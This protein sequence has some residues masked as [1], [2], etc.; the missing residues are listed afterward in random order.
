MKLHQLFFIF[1]IIISSAANAQ[2]KYEWKQ[3][4]SGGYTY[5][6]V[7]NDPM[8]ARFYTLKNGLLVILSPN[9]KEPR[10]SFRIPVRTGSNNDPKDHTGLAHYL[11]HLL[12]KGTD[13]FGSLD[14]ASEKNYLDQI[15]ELYEQ[16]NSTSDV[17]NRKT[18]YHKIDSVS[19]L[20]SRYSIAN[21]YMR[22]MSSI[23]SQA[24]NAHT[25]LEETVY[26]E[27]IPSN[28]VDKLLAVQAERF[29][30]PVFRIFHT[31]LEAVYEEKNRA[32]DNDAWKIQDAMHDLLFPTHNYGRQTTI[33]TIEHLK[34]PSLKAIRE[35]YNKYYVPN[36]MAIVMAGDFEP[37]Q[38]IRKIDSTFSYM[39]PGTLQEYQGPKEEPV[40]G[41]IV[42]NIYGPSAETM[43]LVYRLNG[44]GSR[45]AML[46]N[47]ASSILSNG[48]AGL[49]DLNINKQQKALGAGAG[50]YQYKDYGLFILL[51]SPR[52]DQTLEQV[53]DLLLEQIEMLKKGSF[54]ES[55]IKAIVSNYNLSELQAIE[56]NTYRTQDLVEEFIHNRAQDW[57]REV[58]LLDEMG[59]VSKKEIVEFANGFFGKDNYVVI[60]KRKGTDTTIVK[61]EKPPITPVQTN[62]GKTSPF[63]EAFVKQPLPPIKPVWLDFNKD[64]QKG[65]AGNADILYIPNKENSLYS[66]YYYFNMGSFNNKLL[67]LAMQY[68]QYLGTDKYTAEEITKQFYNLATSFNVSSTNEETYVSINGLQENFE[69]GTNLFEHL[70]QNCKPDVA[71]LEALKDRL[72]KSRANNKLNKQIIS[73]AM[74]NYALYGSQN[75]FNYTLSDEEI[76]KLNA[77]EL[78]NI[79]HTLMNYGHD[80]LYYGPQSLPALKTGIQK[81]HKMPAAWTSTPAAKKFERIKQTVNQVMF[82]DYDAVQAEVFWAKTLQP[83][84][85]GQE[86]L[87]DLYSA[88]FGNGMGSLVFQVIRGSKALAYSTYAAVLPPA[89]KDDHFYFTAYV[90]AQ[91]DK[92]NEAINGMNA[93]INDSLPYN[94]Q[95]FENARKGLLKDI[96]TQR[97][98]KEGIIFAYLRTKKKGVD[99]DLRKEIYDR[100]NKMTISDISRYHQQEL[101]GKPFTYSVIASEKNISM[102]D[103]AKYGEVKKLDLKTLFGY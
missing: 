75:P 100:L 40:K 43:R 79:L 22:M 96:E 32:L 59:K 10:I 31:E 87:S 84:Q 63:V 90:G 62:A 15:D 91:A 5:R 95:D 14:W 29:R 36:N 71:A 30:S 11:E 69:K 20:A 24:T 65:K 38:L 82:T 25:S 47:L 81:I 52:Q 19:G 35:Y 2:G 103:L 89:K 83:Y 37:D 64:I 77:A 76:K 33:G 102:D 86:A 88:Y 1:C 68:L 61:V 58:A 70:I 23:G 18:I 97:I 44:A 56:N 7:T 41:P 12:F 45:E 3:A 17:D 4:A 67:P 13:K 74:R 73:T 48:K 72:L 92:L 26:D 93:L 46:A 94:S 16:Y 9:H 78:V 50:I 51:A 8:R 80:I 34:N 98:T 66:L 55:L 42:K 49:L 99:Y 57:N 60:Y 101:A 53:K 85:P 39:K 28:A 6:Y 27:D 54:D 21:E